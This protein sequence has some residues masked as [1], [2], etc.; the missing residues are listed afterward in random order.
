MNLIFL[1]TETTGIDRCRMIE[2][3][4]RNTKS[5]VSAPVSIRVKPPIPIE[6]GAMAVNHITEKMVAKLKPFNEHRQYSAIKKELESSTIVAHNALFD[7]GVLDREGIDITDYICTKEMAIATYPKADQY[8]LQY[9]RYYLGLEI[10][11]SAHTADG[12]I[13]VLEALFNRMVEDGA[14]PDAFK[15]TR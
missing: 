12:D 14:N 3:A 15:R 13:A 2:L 6:I 5:K 7:L 1:D 8:K 11:G 10:E 9:L 4:Y